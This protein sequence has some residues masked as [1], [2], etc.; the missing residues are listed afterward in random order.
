MLLTRGSEDTFQLH[1][2]PR[3]Q[4]AAFSVY[5]HTIQHCLPAPF[6][7]NISAQLRPWVPDS[8][9]GK[10][11]DTHSQHLRN[12]NAR[13]PCSL[14]LTP[15]T[16]PPLVCLTQ[17]HKLALTN[18]QARHRSGWKRAVE[19]V[20]FFARSTRPSLW[21][22]CRR[23]PPWEEIWMRTFASGKSNDVS[24]TCRNETAVSLGRF[25]YVRQRGKKIQLASNLNK[26]CR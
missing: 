24:P 7:T 9:H 16:P 6:S 3:G 5:N 1:T 18:T 14:L 4:S 15:Y 23:E 2:S 20:P 17:E 12:N 11:P 26:L 10:H 19:K 25:L 13:R 21:A 8:C 22:S